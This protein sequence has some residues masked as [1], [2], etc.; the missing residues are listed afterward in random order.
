MRFPFL[1]LSFLLITGL[2]VSASGSDRIV[3]EAEIFTRQSKDETRRWYVLEQD[4]EV[5]D[6][7]GAGEATK[8]VGPKQSAAASAS[9]RTFLKLLPDT[10]QTHGDKL[11]RGEN[12]S[13]EPG[14]I[15]ILDYPVD[16]PKPGRYYVWVRAYSSGTE[17]NGLHVG[18]DGGWPESGQRMQWCEGKHAWTWQCAQRTAK[19][20]CGEPMQIFL[21]VKIPGKHVVSFS[22]R[23]DGFAFDQ[24]LLTT[25]RG[26]RPQ[27]EERSVQLPDPPG[28]A[29]TD[30]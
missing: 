2:A 30:Q 24:F 15:A 26:Y 4:G 14:K 23:E 18:I 7:A 17:D 19:K 9:G 28:K 10:R 13:P 21:D 8:W 22:M 20:H 29:G 16:F 1:A 25:D 3:V 27:G 11:I 5:P 6:L 12:F